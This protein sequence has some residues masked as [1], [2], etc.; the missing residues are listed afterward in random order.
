VTDACNL[1]CK[2]C[3]YGDLYQGFD[4]RVSQS[5]SFEKVKHTLD[6]L[7]DLW[8]NENASLEL[9]KT[10]VSFYGG[11]PLLNMSLIMDTIEYI[12]KSNVA[13]RRKI[14][15]SMT[16]NGVLINKYMEYLVTNNIELLVSLDGNEDGNAY[17]VDHFGNNSFNKVYSNLKLLQ[18]K[19]PIYFEQC[20]SFNSVLH[21]KN[22]VI[23]TLEF[24]KTEFNKI[25]N[26]SEL[27]GDDIKCG[28]EKEF[29]CL[30]TNYTSSVLS[31]KK[32]ETYHK[33][34]SGVNLEAEELRTFLES[35]S[36]NFYKDY[37]YL[38]IDNDALPV[39]QTG[40]CIPFSKKIFVT[41]NGK[42]LPCE[43]ISQDY[44]CGK[45]T[46]QGVEI[47][48]KAIADKF[49]LYLKKV[50]PL[51]QK[52]ANVRNCLQCLYK[53]QSLTSDSVSC[54]MYVSPHKKEHYIA[55]NMLYLAKH[56]YLYKKIIETD[57]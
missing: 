1:Q 42:I 55:R 31:S 43:R 13:L 38:L 36:G 28:K 11:E 29:K 22:S 35:Y 23:G 44:D 41:V 6:F 57:L 52:C 19:Y 51:C 56:P 3:C 39:M 26:V 4:N 9:T 48:C 18:N 16:T 24:I 5:L 15:Y 45:V 27:S 50:R 17:R 40:V 21:N 47:D 33:E 14:V 7:F 8:E 37:N 32:T 54:Q 49:N 2:Y 34:L 20:V 12:E 46:D 30:Y 53:I 25:S 10:H